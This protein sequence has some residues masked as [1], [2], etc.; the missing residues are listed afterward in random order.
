MSTEISGPIESPALSVPL[1]GITVKVDSRCNILCHYSEGYCYEFPDG[2]DTWSELQ[3]AF[4][5]EP[6]ARKTAERLAEYADLHS[7]DKVSV[8]LHGGEPLRL[9]AKKIDQFAKI[10][11]KTLASRQVHF[12][13]Q[14]NGM[15]LNTR[16]IDVLQ[17]YD[18]RVGVSLDGDQA[19]NDRHR[20]DLA[21]QSTYNR[22]LEGIKLLKRT[23][24]SW[25]LLAVIDLVNDPLETYHHLTA[26][27][28][29]R[30]IDFLLPLGNWD[31]PPPHRDGSDA[32]PYGKWLAEAWDLYLHTATAMPRSVEKF[33][34]LINLLRGKETLNEAFGNPE[35]RRLFVRPGGG[36]YSLDTLT[37]AGVD[38]SE[39][40]KNVFDH[41]LEEAAKRQLELRQKLGQASLAPKCQSCV[42][43]KACGGGYWP[44]RFSRENN[45][46]NPSVYCSDWKWLI[47]YMRAS[48]QKYIELPKLMAPDGSSELL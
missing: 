16:I 40:G 26:L 10:F 47:P 19:A 35:P 11:R 14:T 33:D 39:L 7:L 43:A 38:A 5:S 37:I 31:N 32:A 42:V 17:K 22:V 18:F 12:G 20:L 27:K 28:P 48:L 30:G 23:N 34:A 13:I 2:R 21:G 36:L 24:L 9:G 3:P 15:L 29:P 6:V 4:M 44:H 8:A 1:D 25:G 46:D 45:F 41:T